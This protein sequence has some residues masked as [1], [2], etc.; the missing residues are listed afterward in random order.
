MDPMTSHDRDCPQ[1][2]WWGPARECTQ[3]RKF[4]C[5]VCWIAGDGLC[6][7]CLKAKHAELNRRIEYVTTLAERSRFGKNARNQIPE[8]PKI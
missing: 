7:T 4:I 8:L 5:C 3:C 2:N 1:C 6:E